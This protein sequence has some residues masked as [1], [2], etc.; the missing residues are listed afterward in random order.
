M[1]L[2]QIASPV[3][4]HSPGSQPI[5]SCGFPLPGTGLRILDESGREA[6]ER[7]VGQVVVRSEAM[8]AGYYRQPELTAQ[9]VKDGWLFTGDLG[10]LVGGQ[11]YLCGR[12]KDLIIVG[13]RN[14]YPQDVE[15]IANTTPGVYP[16]RAAA[17]GIQDDRRG[18]EAL[19]LVCELKEELPLSARPDLERAL[20]KRVAQ[21][22]Y[23]TLADLRFVH[24]GWVVKTSNG[25][26]AH[27]ANREKYLSMVNEPS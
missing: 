22:L 13:G 5:V 14:I 1:Q 23:V 2:H 18:T 24:R 7:K 12:T 8:F 25:K 4:P 19:V 16:G 11:I 26:V 3:E 15:E 21:E 6:P 9:S 10:Y 27:G 17:F 20:R